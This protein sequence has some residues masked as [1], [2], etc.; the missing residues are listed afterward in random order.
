MHLQRFAEQACPGPRTRTNGWHSRPASQHYR[1]LESTAVLREI[2]VAHLDVSGIDVYRCGPE[3]ASCGGSWSYDTRRFALV[4]VSYLFDLFAYTFTGLRTAPADSE[5]HSLRSGAWPE[6][7]PD[8]ATIRV[9]LRSGH[10]CNPGVA[11]ETDDQVSNR[12]RAAN[13]A[14]S[15]EGVHREGSRC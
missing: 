2:T 4:R 3:K 13:A 5:Q 1:D 15:Y 14:C 12:R 7:H 10:C 8:V 6:Y 9:L 11:F